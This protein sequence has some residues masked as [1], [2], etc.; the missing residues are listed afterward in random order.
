MMVAGCWAVVR[1]VDIFV[2]DGW[3]WLSMVVACGM[4]YNDKCATPLNSIKSS[5]TDGVY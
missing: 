2:N 3:Y 1:D 5:K 4:S